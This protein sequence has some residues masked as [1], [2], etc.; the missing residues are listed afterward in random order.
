MWLY[1]REED[2]GDWKKSG[3][4]TDNNHLWRGWGLTE[5]MQVGTALWVRI[6]W[7]MYSLPSRSDAA[8]TWC[9]EANKRRIG[10]MT[11]FCVWFIALC[12]TLLYGQNNARCIVS[13][14]CMIPPI[15][16]KF[17]QNAGID[18]HWLHLSKLAAVSSQQ[19][20]QWLY[21]GLMGNAKVKNHLRI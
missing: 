21:T 13:N 3:D 12:V 10:W 7:A 4:P 15:S 5:T 1:G 18:I 17:A 9:L 14:P 8:S 11:D 6:T 2:E 20:E 19:W 16:V